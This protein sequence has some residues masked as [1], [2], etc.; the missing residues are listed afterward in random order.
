M[1]IIELFV[2]LFVV[3]LVE[4][5]LFVVALLGVDQ[6]TVVFIDALITLILAVTKI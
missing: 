3:V 6:N 1:L 4:I 5:L 2:L